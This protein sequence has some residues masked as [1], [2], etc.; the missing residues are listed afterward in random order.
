MPSIMDSVK[1]EVAFAM[2]KAGRTPSM[3]VLLAWL[4]S[5]LLGQQDTY[6]R[7]HAFPDHLC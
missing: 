4:L 2:D 6:N 3:I 7:Q 1:F 5:H